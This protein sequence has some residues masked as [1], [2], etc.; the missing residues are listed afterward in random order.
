M[1]AGRQT[2]F[3]T[4]QENAPDARS[5]SLAVL[6]EVLRTSPHQQHVA[7]FNISFLL[8]SHYCQIQCLC[9]TDTYGTI[10]KRRN[11]PRPVLNQ[12]GTQHLIPKG[13]FRILQEAAL[14]P[15]LNGIQ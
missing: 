15:D 6:Q 10:K 4:A 3:G 5:A 8:F 2:G 9:V 1:E 13:R 14:V 12:F 7:V 11:K